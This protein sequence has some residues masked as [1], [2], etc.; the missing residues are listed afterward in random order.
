[1]AA[2]DPK[3]LEIIV[4]DAPG[5]ALSKYARKLSVEQFMH[6]VEREPVVAM[7]C[8]RKFFEEEHWE[9]CC[10]LE[11]RLT[12]VFASWLTA[13]QLDYCCENEPEGALRIA[14][15]KNPHFKMNSVQFDRCLHAVPP[16]IALEL[17]PGRLGEKFCE[18]ARAAPTAALK[19]ASNYLDV[20]MLEEFALNDPAT[21]L[22][23][24]NDSMDD[25]LFNLCAYAQPWVAIKVALDRVDNENVIRAVSGKPGDVRR[26]LKKYPNHPLLFRLLNL[27]G[28]LKKAVVNIVVS[29][30][31]KGI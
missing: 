29:A 19:H 8:A 24:A 26:F 25:R 13:A 22:E 6:C 18:Y 20:A 27:R 1:M 28:R 16:A 14:T 17:A 3:T 30:I 9:V 4:R 12:L 7:S 11:P 31:A 5:T 15:N 23:F 2:I 21:A 10:K